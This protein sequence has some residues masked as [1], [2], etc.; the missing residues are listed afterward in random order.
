[1]QKIRIAYFIDTLGTHSGGTEKQL[2]L[3]LKHLDRTRFEPHLFC[4]RSSVLLKDNFWLC[5]VHVPR[6]GGLRNPISCFRLLTFSR[7]LK[8]LDFGVVHTFFKDSNIVGMICGRLAG[9]KAV[10]S[11]RRGLRY[12]NNPVE[13]LML[14]TLNKLATDF[15]ANSEKCKLLFSISE[16]I[17]QE[18]IRVIYN[19]LDLREHKT[20]CGTTRRKYRGMLGIQDEYCVVCI[21]ANLRPVKAVDIFLRAAGLLVDDYPLVRFLV[22]GDG[23]ERRKLESLTNELQI[24]NQV[25]FLGKRDDVPSILSACDVGVLSSYFEALSNSIMEYMAAGLPVVC[26]DVGGNGE[27]V[28]NTKNGYLV[29]RG[30]YNQMAVALGKVLDDPARAKRMGDESREKA[31]RMFRLEKFVQRVEAYYTELS[32]RQRIINKW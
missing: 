15:M 7:F 2:L 12:W 3:L 10:I 28:E 16:G 27:L 29:P 23:P 14:K 21:V 17:P 4:L 13:L 8:R 6:L 18:K 30:D 19:G 24:G 25:I 22:I 32:F 20:G 9:V 5:P 1:M 11:S 31:E 26:T